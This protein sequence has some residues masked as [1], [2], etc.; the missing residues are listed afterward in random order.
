[1]NDLSLFVKS[2]FGKRKNTKKLDC[3]TLYCIWLLRTAITFQVV[4]RDTQT[5]I[6]KQIGGFYFILPL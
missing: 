6:C 5:I 1:M 4:L 2:N 3:N